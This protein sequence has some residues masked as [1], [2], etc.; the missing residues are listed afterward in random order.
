MSSPF[1]SPSPDVP[2]SHVL[3][4]QTSVL[5]LAPQPTSTTRLEAVLTLLT[6]SQSVQIVPSLS[7]EL[8]RSPSAN[9]KTTP[10]CCRRD[11]PSERKYSIAC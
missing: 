6:A 7:N 4:T 5:M 1:S 3:P 9:G 2:T 10:D 11:V 8:T